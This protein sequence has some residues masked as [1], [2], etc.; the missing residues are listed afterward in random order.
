MANAIDEMES[1]Y[2]AS[3]Q[4]YQTTFDT[5]MRPTGMAVIAFSGSVDLVSFAEHILSMQ[6]NPRKNQPSGNPEAR[7]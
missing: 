2:G 3:Q 4:Y 6:D 7:G 5:D 1:R